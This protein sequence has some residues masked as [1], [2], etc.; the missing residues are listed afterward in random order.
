MILRR[1]VRTALRADDADMLRDARGRV[2]VAERA[3]GERG[4]VWWTDG[5]PDYNR[6]MARN[7]P[8]A[9]WLDAL[10]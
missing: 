9:A 2:D 4:Q 6:R 7:T 10:D 8:Y 1:D 5:T 3:L